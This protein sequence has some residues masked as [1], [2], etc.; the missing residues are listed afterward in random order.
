MNYSIK[1]SNQSININNYFI[2]REW[3]FWDYSLLI[4]L[5]FGSIG[6]FLSILV[7]NTKELKNTNASLFVSLYNHYHYN[8]YY[9]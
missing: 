9:F 6:N 7:M 2:I 8:K 4:C 5:I 3:D 1:I